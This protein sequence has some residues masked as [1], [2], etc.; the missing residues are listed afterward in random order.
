MK[1]YFL[2]IIIMLVMALTAGAVP[3]QA[4][5][6]DEVLYA[7]R[8]RENGDADYAMTP[9]SWMQGTVPYTP[10]RYL[11][12]GASSDRVGNGGCSY[13][14][15]AYMLLK[16]G[17]LDIRSGEDPISVLDKMEAVKGWL[18]WGKMDYERIDEAYPAVTCHGYKVRFSS[19][20][21]HRQVEE[22]RQLTEEGYFI[23]CCLDG[24]YSNGHY[25][26]IDEILDDDDLVIGDSAYEGTNWSDTHGPLGG[27]LVD[28]SIFT[29]RGVKP[30]DTDS[31]YTCNRDEK[32]SPEA[33]QAYR[34][35]KASIVTSRDMGKSRRKK[36]ENAET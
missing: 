35:K 11:R 29:C 25:I 30:A 15:A 20:D 27:Y 6:R 32:L 34:E 16:M 36:E 2:T 7:G 17:Q 9:A 19:S 33:V 10:D 18:T 13:F 4:F 31:I 24:A 23:I 1:R 5:S 28:Y 14:A 8:L 12:A 22:L 21:Y 26:F 3:V